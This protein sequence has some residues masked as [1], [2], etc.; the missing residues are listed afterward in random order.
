MYVQ[1]WTMQPFTFCC[2]LW[3]CYIWMS[4]SH[5]K[6]M[7]SSF[8]SG[9][10]GSKGSV[11]GKGQAP[12]VP[13]EVYINKAQARATPTNQLKYLEKVVLKALWKHNFAWPFHQPVDSKKLNLPVRYFI[14]MLIYIILL[15]TF[16]LQRW[17]D[18]CLKKKIIDFLLAYY[19][20]NSA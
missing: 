5:S 17:K 9:G 2:R 7:D 16:Q 11:M 4:S 6:K 19:S 20:S 3:R 10:I 14:L 18:W 13:C 12:V 15:Y 1:N 8:S